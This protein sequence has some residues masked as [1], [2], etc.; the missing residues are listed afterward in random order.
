MPEGWDL[1]VLR[2]QNQIPSYCLS[3]MLS[4]PKPLE[5]IQTNL[6]CELLTY[7]ERAAANFVMARPMGPWGGVKR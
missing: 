5:E 6:V 7:K 1:G 3:V 2:D 4:P